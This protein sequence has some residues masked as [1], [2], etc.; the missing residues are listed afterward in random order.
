MMPMLF[1]ASLANSLAKTSSGMPSPSV[2][3]AATLIILLRLPAMT[4]RSQVGFSNQ[5]SSFI[6]LATAIRSGLPS[7]FISAITT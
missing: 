2:S 4:W 6:P 5:T 7:W 1:L 3:Q